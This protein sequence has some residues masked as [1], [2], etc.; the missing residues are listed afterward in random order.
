MS[1]S[2]ESLHKLLVLVGNAEKRK[3]AFQD[4]EIVKATPVM[5][6]TIEPL[7]W[8]GANAAVFK[9]KGEQRTFA[10]RCFTNAV[11]DNCEKHYQ[12]LNNF[13]K[14]RG[15]SVKD[16]FVD[17][18]YVKDGRRPADDGDNWLPIIKM[19][20]VDGQTL[21]GYVG[22]LIEN[23]DQ[24]NLKDLGDKWYSLAAGLRSAGVAHG[25]LQSENIMVQ[26]KALVLVDYDGVWLPEIKHSFPREIGHPNFNHPKRTTGLYGMDLDNFAAYVIYLALR[27]IAMHPTIADNFVD[28]EKL[29][30]TKQDFEKLEV[31]DRVNGQEAPE[32]VNTIL[33]MD[34]KWEPAVRKLR[35][36]L[37]EKP[38]KCPSLDQAVKGIPFLDRDN[39]DGAGPRPAQVVARPT[40]PVQ[41]GATKP[42]VTGCAEVNQRPP[43][44]GTY[45]GDAA[46]SGGATT[47][48][49][50]PGASSGPVNQGGQNTSTQS[51]AKKNTP[52]TLG[53]LFAFLCPFTGGIPA[54]PG[55]VCSIIGLNRAPPGRKMALVGIA[56]T[57]AWTILFLAGVVIFIIDAHSGKMR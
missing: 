13:L 18:A 36:I 24:V 50:G 7:K 44:P 23:K 55:L 4:P 21:S 5:R 54:I 43:V 41:L 28:K 11:D 2:Y 8:S 29:L 49:E 6:N 26:E 22:E 31:A 25:D 52:A 19:A 53:C 34:P 39:L 3:M 20:W 15:K 57:V 33:K 51:T 46:G 42:P 1:A 37:K 40:T 48:A 47:Q 38:E 35:E 30:F 17:V 9:F 32:I 16:Y 27:V 14:G 10:L 12:E 56:V 45:Q